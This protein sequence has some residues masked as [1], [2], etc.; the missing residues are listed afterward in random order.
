MEETQNS[1]YKVNKGGNKYD[2]DLAPPIVSTRTEVRTA[3]S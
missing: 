3:L 1:K 2:E